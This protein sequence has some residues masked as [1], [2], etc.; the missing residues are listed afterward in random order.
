VRYLL[1]LLPPLLLLAISSCT[2][3][4]DPNQSVVLLQGILGQCSGFQVKAP[5]GKKYLLSAS[6]CELLEDDRHT[7]KVT[8]ENGDS[9]QARVISVDHKSDSML[10]E[11]VPG[12]PALTVAG[13]DE[14]GEKVH[15]MGHGLGL[16]TWTV[17]GSIIALSEPMMDWDETIM[18]GGAQPG[19]SGSPVLDPQGDVVGIV[20]TSNSFIT[21][22]VKLTDIQIFLSAY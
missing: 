9:I 11:P 14:R 6:H 12:L 22:F 4:H 8:T 1:F 21:G 7:I 10:L 20:S 3:K 16:P 17:E 13:T 2:Y 15:I 5:S 18:S 19:H